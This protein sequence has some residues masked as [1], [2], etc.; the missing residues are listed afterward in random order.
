MWGGYSYMGPD[1]NSDKHGRGTC[2]GEFSTVP[3]T[4]DYL[5]PSKV[6]YWLGTGH[7]IEAESPIKA[8]SM[9]PHISR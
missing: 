4:W 1:T 6:T 8:K 2:V 3:L 5:D 7:N 9:L